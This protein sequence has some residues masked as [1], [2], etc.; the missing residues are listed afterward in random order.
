MRRILT[1]G[2]L[3]CICAPAW[4]QNTAACANDFGCDATEVCIAQNCVVQGQSSVTLVWQTDTDLDIRLKLPDG[5]IVSPD[6]EHTT[7]SGDAQLVID[8]C[9]RSEDC[10]GGAI[11]PHVEHVVWKTKS[12]SA[13]RYEVWAENHSGKSPASFDVHIIKPDG[14]IEDLSGWVAGKPGAESERIVF[15]IGVPVCSGDADRDGLCDAWEREGIDV[16]G[17]G[18]VDLDLRA[19]GADPNKKD[20]FVEIDRWADQDV[21]GLDA[22]VEAFAKAPV[23]NPDGSTGIRLHL[24]MDDEVVHVDGQDISLVDE[25]S[26]EDIDLTKFGTLEVDDDTTSCS[27]GWF[28]TA[29]DRASENCANII[30][31]KR[32]VYRYALFVW[33]LRG[34]SNSG[35]AEIWGNDLIVSMGFWGERNT[36][37]AQA[38]TFMHELGHTLNLRHGGNSNEGKKANY[39]S[40]MNYTYQLPMAY[41]GRPLDFSRHHLPT[42]DERSLDDTKGIQGPQSWEHVVYFLDGN[43]VVTDSDASQPIDWNQSGSVDTNTRLDSNNNG[44]ISSQSSHCDWDN[45]VLAFQNSDSATRGFGQGTEVPNDEL[46]YDDAMALGR[47][48]DSDADGIVNVDDNCPVAPN[49]DQ[50]DGDGDGVGD[51]CDQCPTDAAFGWRD[52]CL[53]NQDP[54]SLNTPTDSP[55]IPVEFVTPQDGCTSVG[56]VL[57]NL[58]VLILFVFGLRRRRWNVS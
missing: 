6:I 7:R 37:V 21:F 49:P 43:L 46:T 38:G 9:Y 40:V 44:I 31:A 4:A 1:L 48:S 5:T 32:L 20:I 22:V 54:R 14:Q 28:G 45:V 52:G 57:V 33:A 2:V 8:A 47:A 19:L 10:V 13:G 25:I 26:P 23:R 56:N 12:A 18:I 34:R 42:I 51:V 15:S 16:N 53:P 17:D 36:Q 41:A 50:A 35:I 24:L 39:L 27:R 11:R 58:P 55:T 3:A 29:S 30:K